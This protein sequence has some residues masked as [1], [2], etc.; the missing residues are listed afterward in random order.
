M[1]G[2]HRSWA[3][4]PGCRNVFIVFH[5][6]SLLILLTVL[7]AYRE[8]E[9]DI[10][11]EGL[12]SLSPLIMGS[13]LFLSTSVF[14]RILCVTDVAQTIHL[15]KEIKHFSCNI[16]S[17]K[18]HREGVQIEGEQIEV[19]LQ[20]IQI[21]PGDV[22]PN[23]QDLFM[24]VSISASHLQTPQHSQAH[25]VCHMHRGESLIVSGTAATF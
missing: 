15:P 3:S 8:G 21:Y 25:N 9:W 10:E 14:K 2:I 4:W 11:R 19:L 7:T 16:V 23:M 12:L 20:C 13:T 1:P 6:N 17:Y 18:T 24:S 5:L 22:L